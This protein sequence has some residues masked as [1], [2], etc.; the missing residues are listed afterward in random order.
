[1]GSTWLAVGDSI[2]QG[3]GATQFNKSYVYQSRVGLINA[4]NQHYQVRA[5]SG[6]QRSDNMIEFHTSRGGKCDADLITIMI[7]T[8][9]CA[10]SVSIPT[11][12]TNL[13]LLIDA[14]LFHKVVGIGKVVLC[15]IPW[16]NTATTA[17]GINV[18]NYN[19]AII[20]VGSSRSIPVC[21][22][23]AAY[24]SAAFLSDDVH[25][26]DSGHTAIANIL[27]PFLNGLSIW[28]QVRTRG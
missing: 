24:N 26:N 20:S 10:Q 8:N 17:Y 21:N 7:G 13:N 3:T 25:P 22:T 1:M 27:F 19:A 15:T 14:V 6:G 18:P 28:D 23:Y 12:Q 2:T 11:F 4:G 9:D 5:A 16:I